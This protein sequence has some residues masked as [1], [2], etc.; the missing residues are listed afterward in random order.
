[1]NSKQV[2]K[3][4]VVI[5]IVISL[6]G[7]IGLIWSSLSKPDSKESGDNEITIVM[8]NYSYSPNSFTAKRGQKVVIKLENVEGTHNLV[9]EGLN[10]VRS[11]ILGLNEEGTLEFEIPEDAPDE[12]KFFCSIGRHRDLGME[13][14]ITIED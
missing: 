12:Y 4:L 14:T 6:I 1:M 8:D 9:V 13:G 11:E 7:I 3:L 2:V 10:E 5:A